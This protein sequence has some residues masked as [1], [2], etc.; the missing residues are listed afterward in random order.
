VTQTTTIAT[1][2]SDEKIATWLDELNRIGPPETPRPIPD[3]DALASALDYLNVPEDDHATVTRLRET[4]LA[5]DALAGI[6]QRAVNQL[7]QIMD[8]IADPVDFPVMPDTLGELAPF[9]HLY[10][11]LAV[12][13]DTIALH[14]KRGID[15]ATS[16]AI[17]ADIGRNM[18]VHRKR[19]GTHG[20]AAPDWLMLHPRGMIYAFGRFQFERAHIGEDLAARLQA[21]GIAA[22]ADDIGLSLHIPD[23][24]GSLS[25]DA[26]DRSFADART[27]FADHFPE[28]KIRIVW[29]N[30]WLLDPQLRD[31]L[32]PTSNIIDFQNHFRDIVP[33]AWNNQGPLR[34]TFGPADLPLDD[35]PQET[36]LQ[37]A[38]ITH[39]RDGK[40]WTGGVG[41][42]TL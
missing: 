40:T 22:N 29:C 38:V 34:F 11:Y 1:L 42:V 8:V 7:L 12:L 27:F 4:L 17:M 2:R 32:T 25:S 15:D 16:R 28:E 9:F 36:T 3:G 33:G 20:L 24:M 18:L 5:D 39:I 14:Q 41:W 35:Y 30:S 21:Q 19:H 13:P 10:T 6:T 23:F 26:W 31:Y 37:R